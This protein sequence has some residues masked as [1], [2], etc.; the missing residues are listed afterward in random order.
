MM[1]HQVIEYLPTGDMAGGYIDVG[2]DGERQLY[3]GHEFWLQPIG[4]IRKGIVTLCEVQLVR[5]P[6]CDPFGY[7]TMDDITEPG[8]Y[9]IIVTGDWTAVFDGEKWIDDFENVYGEQEMV[10]VAGPGEFRDRGCDE[11]E[12]FEFGSVEPL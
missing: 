3:F 2:G 1:F 8:L 6:G 4:Y 9:C 5:P 12:F 10:W 7:P 11:D